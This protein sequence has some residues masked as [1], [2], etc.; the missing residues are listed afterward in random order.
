MLVCY[1][2]LKDNLNEYINII[3][4]IN[5]TNK[6]IGKNANLDL[7]LDNMIIQICFNEKKR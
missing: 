2:N 4:I 3:D 1:K 6:N 7:A 5:E